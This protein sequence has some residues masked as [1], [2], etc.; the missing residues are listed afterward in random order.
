MAYK[1]DDLLSL[2][3]KERRRISHTLLNSLPENKMTKKEASLLEERLQKI[4][5]GNMKFFT[6]EEAH[7]SFKKA[8]GKK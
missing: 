3:A 2:P 7:K 6:R 8:L 4:E 5:S 1:I